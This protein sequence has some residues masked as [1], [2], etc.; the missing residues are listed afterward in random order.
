MK[1]SDSHTQL[2][3]LK[4]DF[5]A[6][7]AQRIRH[8]P[9]PRGLRQAVLAAIASGLPPRLISKATGLSSTQLAIWQKK[10]RPERTSIEVKTQPRILDVVPSP[11]PGGLPPGFHMSYEAGRLL[12]DFTF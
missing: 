2:G 11:H 8:K 4:S 12:L 6:F 9:F 10:A 1:V 5:E 3:A 7:R